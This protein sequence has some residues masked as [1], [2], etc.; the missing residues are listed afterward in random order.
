MDLAVAGGAELRPR[1][2]PAVA[3]P[4]DEMVDGEVRDL[5]FAELA[6]HGRENREGEGCLPGEDG[7]AGYFFAVL[8]LRAWKNSSAT[9]AGFPT[10]A[11]APSSEIQSGGR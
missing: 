5:P 1:P 8:T 7:P 3:L 11:P 9:A 10:S 6:L 2:I 4:G